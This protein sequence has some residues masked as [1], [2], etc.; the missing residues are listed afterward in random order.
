MQ[1]KSLAF[2]GLLATASAAGDHMKCGTRPPSAEYK[3][4]LKE[5]A[6]KEK[7]MSYDTRATTT[8]PVYV[9]VL[10][11]SED[12]DDGYMSVSQQDLRL[13]LQFQHIYHVSFVSWP[14]TVSPRLTTLMSASPP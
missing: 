6:L 2:A 9:H 11:N 7:Q 8:V 14:L 1:F 10:A 4:S 5:S 12:A 3:A 13:L